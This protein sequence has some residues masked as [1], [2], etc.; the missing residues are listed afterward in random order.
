[1]KK[2]SIYL[3]LIISFL[4]NA[5]ELIKPFH[6]EYE[7]FRLKPNENAFVFGNNVRLRSEANTNSETLDVIPIGKSVEILSATNQTTIYNQIEWIWYKVNY[8]N[9]TGYILGGLLSR[10][11]HFRN[12]KKSTYLT[13]FKKTEKKGFLIIRHIS[14]FNEEQFIEYQVPFDRNDFEAIDFKIEIYFESNIP[15]VKEVIY[16]DFIANDEGGENG[17]QYLFN[18]GNKIIKAIEIV[19]DGGE[20]FSNREEVIL[21]MDNKEGNEDG[22]L[23]IKTEYRQSEYVPLNNETNSYERESTEKE[24]FKVKWTGK[25]I[26]INNLR[27]AYKM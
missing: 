8:E 6:K 5:Q 2:T 9:K 11:T 16:I 19:D 15:K 4:T 13:S 25:E 1:M 23:T 17:G 22:L 27:K 7:Y 14:N 18:D 20:L 12:E 10:Q 3:F 21:P 26:I 24:I